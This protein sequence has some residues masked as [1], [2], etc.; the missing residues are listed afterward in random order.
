MI[1]LEIAKSWG[2]A[3]RQENLERWEDYENSNYGGGRVGEEGVERQDT[4]E[5]RGLEPSNSR[6][7]DGGI[8]DMQ[9]DQG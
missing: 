8:P 3:F 4:Q 1:P 5:R 9:G 6:C 2:S 7:W